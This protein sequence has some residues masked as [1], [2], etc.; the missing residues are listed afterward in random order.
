MSDDI[1]RPELDLFELKKEEINASSLL[2]SKENAPKLSGFLDG[3]FGNP[4]LNMLD[5]SFQIFYTVGLKLKW[6]VFDWNSNKKERA[7]LHINKGIIDNE[8]E[9]FKLNTNIELSQHESDINKIEE[10][11]LA[12]NEIITLRKEVLE[13]T[14]SQLRNGIITTS[15]YITELTNLYEEENRLITHTIQLELAKS[16]YNIIQGN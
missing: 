14:E 6:N 11:I 5:N 12:D 16:N 2:L 1:K 10:L 13:A 4:G 3:G 9:V 15:V 7:A 8:A